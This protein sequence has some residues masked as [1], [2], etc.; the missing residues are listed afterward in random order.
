MKFGELRSIGHNIANSL[1]HGNSFLIGVYGMDV[2]GEAERSTEGFI[3][4]DFVTGVSCGGKPSLSLA[5]AFELC[6][7]AL[8]MFCRTHGASSAAFRRLSARFFGD[9][10]RR[11]FIVTVEDQEGRRAVDEYAGVPGRRV[12]V[13]DPIGR[14]RKKPTT[15]TRVT[16]A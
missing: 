11:R 15:R 6:S 13:L 16:G 8:P 1:A 4:V 5:H 2:F 10:H 7:R 14:V 9:K 12:K 3:E